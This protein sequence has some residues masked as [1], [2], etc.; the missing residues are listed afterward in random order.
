MDGL[1]NSDDES[2]HSP[3]LTASGMSV[4][5]SSSNETQNI[6]NRKHESCIGGGFAEPFS[7][8]IVDNYIYFPVSIAVKVEM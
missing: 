3:W 6:G 8:R 2:E 1:N 7:G 4:F 5:D